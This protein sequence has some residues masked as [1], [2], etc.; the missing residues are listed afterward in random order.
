MET[1][2]EQLTQAL[3]GLSG[4][5][6]AAAVDTRALVTAQQTLTREL[7]VLMQDFRDEL[8]YLRRA[9]DRDA[10]IDER[11]ALLSEAVSAHAQGG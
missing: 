11:L 1:L 9:R 7:V 10:R 4:D 6:R 5:I 2:L 8:A 3:H